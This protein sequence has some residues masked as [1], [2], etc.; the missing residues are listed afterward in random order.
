MDRDW[1]WSFEPQLMG[2]VTVVESMGAGLIVEDFE[3]K[4]RY[5]NRR[6]LEVTGYEPPELEHQP[7]SLLVPEELREPLVEEQERARAGDA[8]TRLAALRRKDGRAIPVA[9][10]PKVA[11][12]DEE[13][14][15]VVLS[16]L[17]DLGEVYAARPIGATTGGLAAELAS[18]ATRLQSLSFTATLTDRR[19]MNAD[20]PV[21]DDLTARE[22]EILILLVDGMRVPGIAQHLFISPHTVRNH[23]K[24]IFRKVG[25]S[26]QRELIEWIKA[27]ERS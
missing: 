24:G 5:A 14:E 23:L 6:I 8:R 9:V 1:K 12:R 7:V 13:S 19:A 18:V 25:V 22:R 4:I 16:V 26:S 3:G 27:P 20:H 10:S 21:L 17:V 11:Q 2:V 15:P